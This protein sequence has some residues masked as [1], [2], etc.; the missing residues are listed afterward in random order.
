MTSK[1]EKS[2]QN[3]DQQFKDAERDVR[4]TRRE[5][6]KLE[7]NFDD[8]EKRHNESNNRHNQ[9]IN[10]LT[11]ARNDKS[12][13]SNKLTE[14]QRF[15]GIRESKVQHMAHSVELKRTEMSEYKDRQR[16]NNQIDA[17]EENQTEESIQEKPSF[18]QRFQQ[19]YQENRH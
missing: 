7:K 8:V 14:N 11:T 18:L 4:S 19:Q 2:K 12:S 5:L 3:A 16:L 9:A 17:E 10:D 15:I 13:I 1:E 6:E